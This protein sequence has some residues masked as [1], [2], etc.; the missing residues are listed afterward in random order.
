MSATAAI[1]VTAH[2]L[3]V[4]VPGRTLCAGLA[5]DVRAGECW[6]VVG[7]NGAGKT[8]LLTTLAGLRPPA[9][10][11]IA[12]DGIPITSLTARQCALKRG[13]L[14]QTS[15]DF[16]PATVLETVLVGRHPHLPRWGWES[17]NDMAMARSALT[18]IGL[19][20]CETREVGTL[21]G[22][23]RRRVAIA[24][25]LAQDADLMLLDE[26]SSHLDLGQQIVV[27]DLLARL[28]RERNKALV[29]VLHDIH[30]ALRYAD[31]AIAI[32]DGRAVAGPAAAVLEPAALSTLFGHPLVAVGSGKTRTL[33]PA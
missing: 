10:G 29:M 28:A 19:A 22:G 8:T 2:A 6:A 21:S 31:A 16:F 33:L 23:E 7:P 3:A 20:G 27:L 12:Y 24:A 13:W 18:A 9:A 30:L 32:G 15:I 1:R 5:I 14:P 17:A 4:T 25:L 11:E 26:P